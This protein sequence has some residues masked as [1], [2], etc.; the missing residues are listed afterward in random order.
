MLS[1]FILDIAQVMVPAGLFWLGGELRRVSR[2]LDRLD[3]RVSLL[4]H[5]LFGEGL[6]AARRDVPH[7]PAAEERGGDRHSSGEGA[8]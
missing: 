2:A 3:Y 5:R 7:T 6:P 4:E 1:D 8:D